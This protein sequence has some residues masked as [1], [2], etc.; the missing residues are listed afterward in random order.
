MKKTIFPGLL[1]LVAILLFACGAAPQAAE[2]PA[3]S[4]LPAIETQAPLPTA[5]PIE[6]APQP[7]PGGFPSAAFAAREALA[8]LLGVSVETIEI[9]NVEPAEWPDGCLGLA[10]P[11][12]MCTMAIVP[13]YRV[14]LVSGTSQ[15]VY[16]T[17]E[18]GASLRREVGVSFAAPGEEVRPLA[19]WQN[20]ECTE[21]ANLLSEGFSYGACGGPY[22]VFP[23]PEGAVPAAMLEFIETFAPFE[24]ETPAGKILFKGTGTETAAPAEQRA[25]AEWM[26]IQALAAQSGRPQA[27]WGLA[28]TYSRQGG[29]AGFCDEMKVYLDGSVLLS[30]CKNVDVDYRLDAEQLEQLYAWYDGLATIDYSYADPGTADAMSTKLAMPAQGARTADEATVNEILAFCAALIQQV[31][32]EQ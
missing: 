2:S 8:E 13:G 16:R 5:T 4:L 9:R 32:A 25:I 14:T 19:A 22:L 7:I 20:P 15:Y 24:A 23:W 31:R 18:R 11:D 26:K 21:T 28:L 29:F 17:D 12:E 6:P 10:L 27:D 1:L 3:E 30:S